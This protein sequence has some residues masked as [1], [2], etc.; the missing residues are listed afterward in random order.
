MAEYTTFGL[1]VKTK[2][3][4][5]PVR[6]QEWLC[7]AVNADTGLKIDSAYMSKILTGQ[8]TSARV[9]QSICKI[10]GIEADEK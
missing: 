10:L 8:R 9:A 2:L 1:V 4:G 5:P 6:T 3:L 7:A